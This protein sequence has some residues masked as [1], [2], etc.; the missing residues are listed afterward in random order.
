MLDNV[1]CASLEVFVKQYAGR[2]EPPIVDQAL[3]SLQ[4]AVQ[5]ITER[6]FLIGFSMWLINTS[7]DCARVAVRGLQT[8]DCVKLVIVAL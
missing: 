8:S 6:L 1:E 7:G 3:Q 2:H 4:T 5:W